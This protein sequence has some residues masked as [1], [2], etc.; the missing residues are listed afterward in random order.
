MFCISLRTNR[1]RN[2]L[3]LSLRALLQPGIRL[4]DELLLSRS[5]LPVQLPDL[6]ASSFAIRAVLGEWR[7]HCLLLSEQ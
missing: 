6:L 1:L 2:K 3:V 7:D 5:L 4:D